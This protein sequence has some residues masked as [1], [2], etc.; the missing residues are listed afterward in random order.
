MLG[1]CKHSSF[2]RGTSVVV[3]NN[4]AFFECLH[5]MLV[6]FGLGKKCVPAPVVFEIVGTEN[7]FKAT[8][9]IDLVE[10]KEYKWL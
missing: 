6:W 4:T 1:F 8:L 3:S 7:G 10:I 5:A 2:G 9:V